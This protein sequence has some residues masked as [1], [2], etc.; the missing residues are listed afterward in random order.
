MSTMTDIEA[1]ARLF[2][3]RRE[4]L[5]AIVAELTAAID[6]LKRD[7][8]AELKRAV[9]AAAEA[10]EQLR[11]LIEAAPQLFDRP[12]TVL[13]HGIKLGYQKGKGSIEFD[14]PERLMARI[15]QHLPEQAEYLI[16][17]EYFPLKSALAQLPAA[18]LKKIGVSIVGSDDQ[19]VIKPADSG[20]DKLVEALVKGAVE[21]PE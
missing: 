20:V 4:R 9:G 13:L 3:A 12:R 19:I 18:D 6:A 14:S 15:R 16:G 17:C 2:A 1:R 10:H 5:A 7:R 11:A 21:Q 8:M